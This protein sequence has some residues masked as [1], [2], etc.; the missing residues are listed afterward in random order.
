VN[1]GPEPIQLAREPDFRLGRFTVRPSLGEVAADGVVERLEPRVMQVLVA[2]VRAD[3][4]V[5]SRDALIA[6]CWGG[7]IVSENAID[8]AISKLRRL[9]ERDGAGF[10]VE[11]LPRIGVR[12]VR[13]APPEPAAVPPS[14]PPHWRARRSRA[15]VAGAVAGAVALAGI[16]GAVAWRAR[17]P[18]DWVVG[19]YEIVAGSARGEGSPD[20]SP[21]GR[22]L[23]YHASDDGG[24]SDIWFR[25]VSGGEAVRLVGGP[26][27]DIAPAWSP[28][29]DQI[30]F[31]RIAPDSPTVG[32]PCSIYVKPVPAGLERLVGRCRQT[33]FTF[34]VAWTP[35]GDALIFSESLAEDRSFAQQVRRLDLATGVVS[36]LTRS[37]QA[38]VGDLNATISPD[39]RTLAFVRFGSNM[40]GD[41]YTQDLRSGR[42]TRVTR[43]QTGASVD[44]S[45]DGRS[46][47]VASMRAG[48]SEL[49]SFD[50][51]GRGEPQRLM[52]GLQNVHR[53]STAPGLVAFSTTAIVQEIVRSSGGIETPVAS[54]A[55]YLSVDV[56]PDG[57]VAFISQEPTQRLWLQPPGQPA[58]RLRDLD[59]T[60]PRYLAFSPDGARLS[61]IADAEDDSDIYLVEAASGAVSRLRSP[62]QRVSR[63]SWTP[64]GRAL[65]RS[66]YDG[67]VGG[68]ARLEGLSETR[69]T[70]LTAPGWPLSQAAPEGVFASARG[71][72]GVWRIEPG[73]RAV[74]VAPSRRPLPEWRVARGAV[75]V[76]E[77]IDRDRSVILRHP[78]TGGAPVEVASGRI[79]DFAV[80]PRNGDLLL[81][82]TLQM[83]QDIGLLRVSRR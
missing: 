24:S 35:A 79:A 2:L 64:D 31:L 1:D 39:G 73:G 8:R 25:S 3:G 67:R 62:D 12:L 30:A 14:P 7:V 44:W 60:L 13:D 17:P 36:D 28:S 65:V 5:A 68:I 54:G 6:D 10:R 56:A 19:D 11:T 48:P 77:E 37:P 50:P 29:G 9:A 23:V 34:R 18:G 71:R 40:A 52:V 43:D 4:A 78:L 82:R 41:V 53:P 81:V 76:L 26:G 42:L 47:F 57:R 61:L 72:S 15:F 51:R 80:D 55:T 59:L 69:R 33:A 66:G 58:R 49:W 46:L 38:S 16:V 83:R 74:L 70:M 63:A 21:D 75:F 45:P 22:F 27:E 32:A 20:L